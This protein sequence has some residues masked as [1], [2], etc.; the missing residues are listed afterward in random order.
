MTG[1]IVGVTVGANVMFNS[2]RELKSESLLVFQELGAIVTIE[3]L[4][5]VKNSVGEEV[6]VRFS[7]GTT[8]LFSSR[9]EST[10]VFSLVLIFLNDT[11][12]FG[13]LADAVSIPKLGTESDILAT[14]VVFPS[15]LIFLFK[16]SSTGTSLAFNM[17]QRNTAF[18]ISE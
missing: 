3:M 11:V 17:M 12:S 7:D 9:L 16:R 13:V 14:D 4:S 10:F 2:T 15:T 6:S 5:N 1:A 18:N 8:A